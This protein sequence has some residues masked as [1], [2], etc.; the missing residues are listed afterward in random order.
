VLRNRSVPIE[1]DGRGF[2]L[3]GVND[4][5]AE[6]FGGGPEGAPDLLRALEGRDPQREVVLL[7]HQPRAVEE[8]SQHDVGLVLSGH[9]HGGQLWPWMHMVALQ[10][11]YIS[12]LH[13]HGARTQIYVSEGTGYWGPPMRVGT[14]PEITLIR[15]TGEV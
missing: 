8:A 5:E 15:L 12:G 13:G 9:T 1:V 2:D 4:F 3:A 14:R 6:R 10:Q 7:A 11:P